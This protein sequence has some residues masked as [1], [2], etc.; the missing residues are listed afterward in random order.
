MA[1]PT[2]SYSPLVRSRKPRESKSSQSQA[3]SAPNAPANQRLARIKHAGRPAEWC[4]SRLSSTTPSKQTMVRQA[5]HVRQSGCILRRPRIS[6]A[7]FAT[8]PTDWSPRP[9]RSSWPWRSKRHLPKLF[10][11]TAIVMD[12]TGGPAPGVPRASSSP[13]SPS[14]FRI[15]AAALAATVR[16]WGPALAVAFLQCLAR[17][18]APPWLAKAAVFRRWPTTRPTAA[19]EAF[20]KLG[21]YPPRGPSPD[22]AR[23]REHRT[24][25]LCTPVGPPSF[26]VAMAAPPTTDRSRTLALESACANAIPDSCLQ[27]FRCFASGESVGRLRVGG[28]Q[29]C[30]PQ[31][32]EVCFAPR[33]KSPSAASDHLPQTPSVDVRP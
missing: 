8:A 20:H 18:Q 26:V 28:C 15:A 23:S 30:E 10:R 33:G 25:T 12:E 4:I 2:P 3:W 24:Q 16:F 14:L 31:S 13:P 21:C 27:G 22:V 32:R 1:H 11:F 29:R 7:S 5:C 9:R 6:D 17:E 19:G